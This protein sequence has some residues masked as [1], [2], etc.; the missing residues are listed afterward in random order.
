[1]DQTS[2]V[3]SRIGNN[4]S[5]IGNNVPYAQGPTST[6]AAGRVHRGPAV[7]LAGAGII[8][9][10][11]VVLLVLAQY[12]STTN[13]V[14]Y[15]DHVLASGGSSGSAW[16]LVASGSKLDDQPAE[17]CV[18][19]RDSRG[20]HGAAGCGYRPDDPSTHQLSYL[21]GELPGGR[22]QVFFGPAPAESAEVEFRFPGEPPRRAAT[23]QVA[24]LPGRFYH[25]IHPALRDLSDPA[26]YPDAAAL[27]SAERPIVP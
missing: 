4:V 16:T 23:V 14:I 13:Q 22:Q 20:V 5:R 1:M 17:G 18:E 3:L 25:L 11:L 9:A 21:V 2:V 8:A 27:N 24:G 19:L 10:V 26:L 15:P 12:R 6:E 7:V